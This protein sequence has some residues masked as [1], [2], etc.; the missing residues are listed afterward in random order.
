MK[1]KVVLT[2][3]V[4][5]DGPIHPKYPNYPVT[6]K[7][8]ADACLEA[9]SAGA[10]VVHIHGRDPKTGAGDRSPAVFREIVERVRDVN[11]SV[12]INL[13]TGMGGTFVPEPQNEALA[14]PTTDVGTAEERVFH[15]LENRPEICTLDATTMNLEGGIAGAPDCVFMNTPGKL[16]RMAELIRGTGTKLEIE[17]FNPGD[18]LLARKMVEDGH[19]DAPPL[20]QICL[21][22]KWSAPADV[23]TLVYMKD[24]L[25]R[26][27]LWSAFG[28][29]RFQMEIVA[30]STMM[31]GHCRVGLE[32]NIYLERGVFASN[33]QLVE[34]A[35][36]IIRD[37]G[38]EVAAPGD[39][40]QI[41]GLSGTSALATV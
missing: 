1:R 35:S 20:F 21:G 5:G 41:F 29:S 18:I 31:G 22:V 10:S 11:Q 2:C 9:A 28:I 3:A 38:C 23:K 27:A 16:R 30:L 37:L 19:I 25:P 8:I 6:P 12:I 32:D 4:T 24:L 14:H 15:V 39:A 36:R 17:V 7:Q 26:D 40:R 33:G 34:R 13:T